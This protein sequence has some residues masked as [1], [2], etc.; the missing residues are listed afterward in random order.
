MNRFDSFMEKC[1][2][3]LD[4]MMLFWLFLI[5]LCAAI[6]LQLHGSPEGAVDWARHN[7]DLVLA[8]LLGIMGGRAW[9]SQTTKAIADGIQIEKT[10]T[11]EVAA[12][13][14]VEP[15]ARI[16]EPTDH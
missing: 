11:G 4:K 3:N 14:A 2:Q 15:P 7:T 12:G 9:A 6:W 13:P 8:G 16:D 5:S 1:W 10:S